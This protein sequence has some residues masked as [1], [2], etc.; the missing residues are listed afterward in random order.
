MSLMQSLRALPPKQALA[1]ALAEKAKRVKQQAV[2]QQALARARLSQTQTSEGPPQAFQVSSAV[3]DP[4]HPI[5][6]IYLKKARYKVVWG[7]RGALKSWSF[8]EALV[9]MAAATQLRIF[10]GREYQNSI[11]ESVHKLLQTTINRLGYSTWFNVN[12]NSITSRVGSEFLFAGLQKINSLR[13]LEDV[14]IVWITEAAKVPAYTWQVLLPTIRKPGSEVWIDFNMDEENDAT[15]Q[16]FVVNERPRSIVHKIN[17]DQNPWFPDE[18]REEMEF[19]K[20]TNPDVY[21]HVWLGMPK[22]KS[23]AIILNGKYRITEFADDLWLQAER[24]FFGADHGFANDP[25]TLVRFF[26]I[27]D[28]EKR[29]L[30]VEHEAYG[31]HVELDDL[32]AFYAGGVGTS[33]IGYPGIPEARNWPI[34]GDCSRPETNS[35]VRRQGF[36]IDGAD[37]WPGCV[38]DGITHL[39]GFD[40][41]IIHPRC[42]K[43]AAEAFLWRY[44]TDTKQLDEHGQPQVLPIVIDK[45]NHCW[46][47]VRYGLDGYI[48]RGGSLGQWER[49]ST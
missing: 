42:V 44:K 16:T 32:P 14:D 21:D 1:L 29:R 39:R 40:E 45:H 35:Y 5:S 22:K 43:T 36:N 23:N 6:D 47:A 4:S 19:D 24:L 9:R 49:L 18:L 11:Q 46:D 13:S 20:A 3:L 26:V 10:C 2:H 27:E 48:Q 12:N 25:A 15:Y 34:K 38:E 41:I 17:Y 30:Y 31:V 7:G 37:K 33:G 8:A 28:G